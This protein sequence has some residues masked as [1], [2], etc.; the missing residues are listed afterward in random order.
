[1]GYLNEG[2][3]TEV[4]TIKKIPHPVR[5]SNTQILGMNVIKLG[6]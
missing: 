3:F 6:F 5:G 1:M 2:E 4:G